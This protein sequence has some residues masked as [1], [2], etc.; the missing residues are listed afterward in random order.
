MRV[1]AVGTSGGVPTARY[2]TSCVHLNLFGDEVLFDC[3]EGS[4]QRLMRYDASPDV[5]AVVVS[6]FHADH[7]LGLPGLVQA[8]EMNDRERPLDVHVPDGRTGRAVD[9]IEG[10]YGRPSYPVEVHGYADDG[11]VIETEE[12]GIRPFATPYTD[13]SHGLVVEEA[14]RREFLV[15]EAR[16]LGVDPGPKYG[17]LQEGQAV[18]ADDGTTVEP[19]DVLSEPVAGRTVVYTGDTRPIPAV[20]EA[21][22]D[23]SLLI[24]SAMFA[25]AEAERARSTGHSTAAEAGRVAAEAGSRRLWLTHISPRHEDEEDRLESEAAA[26]F[27]GE[28]VAVRDGDST[29]VSRE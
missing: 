5:D 17:R 11:P 1:T 18:E 16:A 20:V 10:A 2:G 29:T 24:Y 21:A 19:D 13:H 23:A 25:E 4:G 6:H 22:S 3:G 9:T 8:L 15:E 28:V 12:Y 26:A 27:D 7:T 14:D